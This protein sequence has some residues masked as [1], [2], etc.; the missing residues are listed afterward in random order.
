ML[1]GLL[2]ISILSGLTAAAAALV[3]GTT[4]PMA[5]ACYVLGGAFGAGLLILHACS[6]VTDQT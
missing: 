1:V 5:L 6:G 3:A 4:L 2:L